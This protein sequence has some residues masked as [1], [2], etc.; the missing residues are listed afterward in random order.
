MKWYQ[1]PVYRFMCEKAKEIQE[2][3]NNILN[4]CYY[5]E[6]KGNYGK[7]LRIVICGKEGFS[8]RPKGIW[9]PSQDHLQ[10]LCVFTCITNVISLFYSFVY[11]KGYLKDKSPAWIFN[12][13]EQLWLAFVMNRKYGKIWDNEVW[14]EI[15]YKDE[16]TDKLIYNRQ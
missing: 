6:I 11:G 14:V 7:E 1:D 15:D 3:E 9:L 16:S 4:D 10:E 13:M 12:S 2:L 8:I 5:Y